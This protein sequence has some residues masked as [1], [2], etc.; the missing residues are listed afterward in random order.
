MAVFS[1]LQ[2]VHKKHVC[3]NQECVESLIC[4]IWGQ[5]LFPFWDNVRLSLYNNYVSSTF[6][7]MWAETMIRQER[8]EIW[9]QDTGEIKGESSV[10]IWFS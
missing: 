8:E 6:L 3:T 4:K 10:F 7:I 5:K 2:G 9:R 1:L